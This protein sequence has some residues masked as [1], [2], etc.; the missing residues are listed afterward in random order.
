MWYKV[1]RIMVWDKQVR[2]AWWTPDAS[3]TLL[4]LPLESNATDYSWNSITTTPSNVT[5]WTLWWVTC[6]IANWSSSIITF[7][8]ILSSWLTEWTVSAFLYADFTRWSSDEYKNILYYRVTNLWM[9]WID[10]R[11]TDNK[12]KLNSYVAN[13]WEYYITSNLSYKWHHILMTFDNSSVKYY[14]DWNKIWD[15]TSSTSSVWWYWQWTWWNTRQ[16]F[17]WNPN[18]SNNYWKWWCREM[19][20]EKKMWSDDDITTYYNY[21]KTKLWIN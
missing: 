17:R 18:T 4:Y 11:Y 14:W 8:E 3:R 1:K 19:I 5:Y 15:Y 9:V 6:A 13:R 21:M 7:N 16:I 2:P 10:A 20:F 12:Q